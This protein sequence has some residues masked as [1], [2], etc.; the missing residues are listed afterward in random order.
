MIDPE[1]ADSRQSTREPDELGPAYGFP[2]G[3]WRSL[4]R[5]RPPGLGH[6]KAWRSPLRGPWLTSVFGSILLVALP[7]IIVTGLLSYSAYGPQFGQAKPADVGLLHLPF[8]DWPTHPSWLYRLTQG[9]HVGLGLVIIPLVLAK[10]WSVVP[11]LFSWPPARSI[12]QVLERLSLLMLVGGILFELATGV[13]NIQYDYIFGFSFYTAHYYGAWVF[14]AGFIVHVGTKLPLMW[15]ALHSRSF[16][17]TMRTSRADTVAEPP[18]A[19]GLVAADPDPATISRRGAIALVGGGSLLMLAL[20]AGQTIG[21]FTRPLA[22]LLPRG[23]DMGGGP[24]DFEI[25]RTAA[26]AKISAADVG[27]SWQLVL[28]GG[29]KEILLDRAALLAMTQHTAELPIACVEGWS[30]VQTWTGVRLR[31]LAEL[32]GVKSPHSAKVL[33][34]QRKG[35]FNKAFL[36][37][38]QVL[39]GDSLLALQVNGVDL[40]MDHGYPARIIVPAMPGVHNTKWVRAIEFKGA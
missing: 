23:R 10:L 37:S 26:A 32:A 25:N 38:N 22:V 17:D 33:S 39:N 40:S 1:P 13:L 2:A 14:M 11:R 29:P 27:G 4:E 30:T 28:T 34:L 24:N 16:V 21:G 15:A 31:D 8:F 20:T 36:Q 9:L 5:H 7:I 6:T 18:D 35:S 12:A 3:L 19:G